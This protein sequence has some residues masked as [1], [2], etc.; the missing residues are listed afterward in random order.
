[1]VR[2]GKRGKI[3]DLRPTSSKVKLALFNILYDIKGKVFLDLFAGS[4]QIG[5]EALKKGADK[6][7]F[8]EI[9][10]KRVFDI[11]K[12]V[13]LQFSNFEVHQGDSLKFLKNL[14]EKVD[15]I[16][17]DPPYDYKNYEKLIGLAVSKLSDD[18][19]FI[20]EH[21][22]NVDFNSDRKKKYGDTTLS[23]FFR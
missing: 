22:A 13:S 23:F 5:L 7:I 21:S 9:D 19:V 14:N 1:M 10:R 18:G 16:F 15:I 11:K 3:T 2:R 6:V 12:K 8:V 17:A 20:L 4:G